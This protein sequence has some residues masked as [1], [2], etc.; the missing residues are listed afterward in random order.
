MNKLLY[1]LLF[2]S[3]SLFAQRRHAFQGRVITPDA[4]LPGVFVINKDTGK[5]TKSGENGLF[6]LDARAGDRL[7]VYSDRVEVRE[8]P[9]S[10]KSFEE[11]PYILE[12]ELKANELK[13]VVVEGGRL[14]PEA[15]GLVEQGQK[16]YTVAQRRKRANRT[17][18]ANQGL[19]LSIDAF[20]NKLNGRSRIIKQNVKTEEKMAALDKLRTLYTP[21][22]VTEL[23]AIPADYVE[24]FLYYVI[25]DADCFDAV[26]S[27]NR[28]LVKP[29]LQRLAPEYLKA[30]EDEK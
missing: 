2:C 27:N 22:E 5:E 15:M 20:S 29:Q 17:V 24:G 7:A 16:Q 30:I 9:L 12:V 18:T 1:F 6:T 28:K 13:E 26:Q 11:Q 4:P 10:D 19:N 23:F 21:E 8:F 25:E 14:D 3:L